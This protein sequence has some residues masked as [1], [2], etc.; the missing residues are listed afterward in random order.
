[1]GAE[2]GCASVWGFMLWD[3]TA[4]LQLKSEISISAIPSTDVPAKYSPSSQALKTPS[5]VA[6]SSQRSK[7]MIARSNEQQDILELSVVAIPPNPDRD[8]DLL[9]P[10]CWRLQDCTSC[11]ESRYYCSWC[12][13][14]RL[15]QRID[16][17]DPPIVLIENSLPLV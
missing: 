1:M 9:L 6:S 14:V 11:L 15:S 2:G 16:E 3:R 17:F 8:P 7:T 13:I 10:L 5:G 12:P 4:A